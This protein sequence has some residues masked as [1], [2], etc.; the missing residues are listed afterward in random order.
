MN[1]RHDA[2]DTLDSWSGVDGGFETSQHQQPITH[3]RRCFEYR[4]VANGDDGTLAIS[5][6]L[7]DGTL[8]DGTLALIS[9]CCL[10]ARRGCLVHHDARGP[11]DR[12]LRRRASLLHHLHL[13]LLLLLLLL[14]LLLARVPLHSNPAQALNIA[15]PSKRQVRGQVRPLPLSQP[16][17]GLNESIRRNLERRHP[18]SHTMTNPKRHA[19]A[20]ATCARL[21]RRVGARLKPVDR[22]LKLRHCCARPRRVRRARGRLL[23]G[24][25]RLARAGESLARS[26]V[27]HRVHSGA[28]LSARVLS[29]AVLS[30]RVHS[31]AVLS[32]RVLS[33]TLVLGR[34]CARGGAVSPSASMHLVLG[35]PSASMHL[36][37][38]GASAPRESPGMSLVCLA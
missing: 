8:A 19:D 5:S 23:G 37:L 3:P 9:A 24:E 18:H 28:V 33:G 26:L 36:V 27:E 14:R 29:G 21:E 25:A 10:H 20:C 35:G 38:G 31:G 16:G 12:L 22:R 15:R 32:A 7:A 2:R 30:A 4:G 11:C 34:R 17:E 6:A 1:A 13:L